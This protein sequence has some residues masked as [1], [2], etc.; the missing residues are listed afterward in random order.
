MAAKKKT[1]KVAGE[2]LGLAAQLEWVKAAPKLSSAVDPKKLPV[3]EPLD[4]E[5]TTNVLRALASAKA[6]AKFAAAVRNETTAESRDALGVAL[7]EIWKSKE[8]HGRLSWIMDA[9]G[10]LGG[11]RSIMELASH[12]A[13]WP[14]DGDTGR[15]RA[16]AAAGVLAHA[17]TDTAILELMSLRQTAVVPSVLEAT[18]HALGN[19]VANRKTTLSELFDVVTPTL[20]LDQ[21]GTRAFD[22]AGHTYTVAFDDHFEPRLRDAA[23]DLK[24]LDEEPAWNALASK[25]RDAVKV[26]TFRLEQDMIAG[27]RWSVEGWTRLLRD[28]PLMVSF[29]RRLVWGVYGEDDALVTAFRTAEER[30]LL[31]KDGDMKLAGDERIGLVHPLQLSDADRAAWGESLADYEIIQPFPQI[32]RPIHHIE[33]AEKGDATYVKRYATSRFKSGVL[34]DV[35]VRGGWDRDSAFLRK[36]YERHYPSDGVWAIAT[37]EPG[38]Q[39]GMATYDQ[40]DQTIATIEFREKKGGGKSRTPMPL[41]DVPLVPFSEAIRDIAEVLAAQD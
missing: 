38:V 35:L 8:F 23:G 3:L 34:R 29:T 32:G 21:N 39:A 20:G 33:E 27:R 12:V 22:H 37:M 14:K 11:D 1:P 41:A 7:L 15:K 17:R 26:Q 6:D 5:T 31:T 2:T 19:A 25:L 40:Y 28:H 13:A 10:A 16:I 4:A 18:I 24:D 36:E 9:I 30:T